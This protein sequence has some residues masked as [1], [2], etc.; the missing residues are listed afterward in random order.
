MP[1]VADGRLAALKLADGSASGATLIVSNAPGVWG[2]STG[3]PMLDSY[4]FAPNG[5]NLVVTLTG[6]EP[7][8]YHFYAYGWAGDD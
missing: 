7:G 8:S 2:N 1:L 5:S 4:V 3:D 6:L